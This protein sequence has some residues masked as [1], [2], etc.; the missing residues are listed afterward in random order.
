VVACAWACAAQEKI[1]CRT[2]VWIS[3]SFCLLTLA[4]FAEAQTRK[5]G[6]WELTTTTTWQRSPFPAS[7]PPASGATHTTPVCLTQQQIDKYGAILPES[8]NNCQVIHLVKK[9]TSMT[10]DMV[11]TGR[12][13]GKVSLEALFTDS[14]HATGKV[15]FVGSMQIGPDN[16]PM[17]WTSSSV[18]TFKGSDC[19]SVQPPPMPEK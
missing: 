7:G 18:S 12:M 4:V 2:R 6:L 5:P 10:A 9:S 11:C 19:G 17:E 15:H 8:R 14:E 16:K 1:M 3:T 13:S